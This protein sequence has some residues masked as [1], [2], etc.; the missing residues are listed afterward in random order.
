MNDAAGANA[1]PPRSSVRCIYQRILVVDDD[2]DSAEVFVE[3][4]TRAGHQTKLALDGAS[5]IAIAKVFLPQLILLDIQLSNMDGY[6]VARLLRL[7][8]SLS[9]VVLAAVTGWSGAERELQAQ[10]AGFDHYFVK[11]MQLAALK[12]LLEA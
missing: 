1:S 9:T 2:Q 3:I 7:E 4:L 11:P 10:A 6:E 12:D 5:A 8:P